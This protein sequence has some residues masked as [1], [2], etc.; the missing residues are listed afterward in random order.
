MTEQRLNLGE[1]PEP[2]PKVGLGAGARFDK[3]TEPLAPTPKSTDS[4]KV[5]EMKKIS[6]QLT[7]IQKQYG[8]N[9]S[10]VPHTHEYWNL[11]GQLY[12]L[13]SQPEPAA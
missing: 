2:K 6:D 7:E 9:E 5:Q 13:Q 4:P 12:A 1:P 10:D 11:R 3:P 8:G